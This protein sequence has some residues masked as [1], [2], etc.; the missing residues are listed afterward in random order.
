MNEN[1]EYKITVELYSKDAGDLLEV[2]LPK[3]MKVVNEHQ[4]G[5]YNI[6]EL[7][8]REIPNTQKVLF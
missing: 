6:G 2:L 5:T 1:T 8:G 3:I 4:G 7:L